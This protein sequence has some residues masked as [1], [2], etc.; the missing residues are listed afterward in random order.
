LSYSRA[1]VIGLN[2]V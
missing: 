2:L 1:S